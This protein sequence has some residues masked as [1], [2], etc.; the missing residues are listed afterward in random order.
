MLCYVEV[1]F[2][3]LLNIRKVLCIFTFMFALSV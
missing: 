1:M 3:Q 2:I